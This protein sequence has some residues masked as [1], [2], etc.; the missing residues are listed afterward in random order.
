MT[1]THESHLFTVLLLLSLLD[2]VLAGQV[3]QQEIQNAQLASTEFIQIPGPNP[4]L[5][6]SAA[7]WDSGVIEAADALKDHDTYYLY[8][9]GTENSYQVGVASA[10]HPLGPWTKYD[11]NPILKVGPKNAWDSVHVAC[12]FILKEKTN[13]YTMWYSGYGA[14]EKWGIGLATATHPLGPWTK[15]AENPIMDHFGYVGGVVKHQDQYYLYTAHPIGSTGADYSPMSLAIAEQP[16]GPYQPYEGNP[17]LKPDPW[18]S[19]DDGGYSEAEVLFHDGVFHMFYG[20]GKLHPTRILTRESI[21]YAYSLDGKHFTKS[22]R[23]PVAVREM[24]PDGA[25]FAEVHALVEGPL[26]YLF[27]TLRYNSRQ[28]A[29]DLGVQVLATQRPFKLRMPV[30]IKDCLTPKTMTSLEESVPLCLDSVTSVMIMAA[31]QY[32][33]ESVM[34][35]T[36]HV[37]ASYDG[38]AYDTLDMKT[39]HLPCHPGKRV[40]QTFAVSAQTRYLKVQVKN[41]DQSHSVSGVEVF[42]TLGG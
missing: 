41:N 35:L 16:E 33:E 36:I 39:V 9:H 7:G 2:L 19:W 12:A 14:H 20:A 27:H 25:A 29:E 28:G 37:K 26:I 23:N 21:G 40:S 11:K 13:Q 6:P 17:V 10:D 38:L 31:C 24:V 22:P 8:Y 18:G 15:Y 30:L 34:P 42:A 3:S 4:I 1:K 5:V 32:H